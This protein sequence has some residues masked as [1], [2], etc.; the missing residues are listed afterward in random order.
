[1]AQVSLGVLL[2]TWWEIEVA[3]AGALLVIAACSLFGGSSAAG[4]GVCIDRAGNEDA[5]STS[6]LNAKDKVRK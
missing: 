5:I 1:M 3:V 2:P 4:G 6:E